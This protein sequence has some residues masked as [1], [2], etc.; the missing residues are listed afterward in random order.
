MS[1]SKNSHVLTFEWDKENQILEIHGNTEG[2]KLLKNKIDL[3]IN[4]K[5]MNHTHLMSREWGGDE[6]T[7]SKQSHTNDMINSVKIFKWNN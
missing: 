5:E 2:L 1:S 4:K 6:I 3:I 7:E